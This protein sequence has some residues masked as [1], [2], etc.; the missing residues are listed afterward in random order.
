MG[1]AFKIALIKVAKGM[2]KKTPQNPQMPPKKRT[3]VTIITGCKST[4]SANKI[5]TN[6]FPSKNCI[7]R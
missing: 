2:A 6:I 7:A 3:A 5:G 4:T 1:H